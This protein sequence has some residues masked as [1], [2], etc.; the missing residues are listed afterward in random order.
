MLRSRYCVAYLSFCHQTASDLTIGSTQTFHCDNYSVFGEMQTC[1]E[2]SNHPMSRGFLQI[3]S[4]EFAA[5]SMPSSRDYHRK[6]SYPRTQQRDLD[7][8]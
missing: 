2:V 5:C 6:A 3:L 8:G 7:A 1:L 4:T